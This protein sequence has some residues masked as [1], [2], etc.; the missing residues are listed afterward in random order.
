VN[1][2]EAWSGAVGVDWFAAQLDRLRGLAVASAL[3]GGLA[4]DL[5]AARDLALVI[6]GWAK[7]RAGCGDYCC[8]VDVQM[9]SGDQDRSHTFTV[10]HVPDAADFLGKLTRQIALLAGRRV[11]EHEIIH[12]LTELKAIATG[13]TKA[14]LESLSKSAGEG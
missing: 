10:P 13:L 2:K 7:C 5:I 9:R 14:V 8:M 3:D 12:T 6:E 1:G 11:H 4:D